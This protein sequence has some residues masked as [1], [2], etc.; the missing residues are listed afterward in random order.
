M[1]PPPGKPHFPRWAR[2]NQHI[3]PPPNRKTFPENQSPANFRAG[4]GA[5]PRRSHIRGFAQAARPRAIQHG[6]PCAFAYIRNAIQGRL[7]LAN[8]KRHTFPR[9]RI[10]KLGRRKFVPANFRA[11][12]GASAVMKNLSGGTGAFRF[13]VHIKSR[14]LLPAGAVRHKARVLVCLRPLWQILQGG[15]EIMGAR[16]VA[17]DFEDGA[18]CRI[19]AGAGTPLRR[20]SASCQVGAIG[21]ASRFYVAVAF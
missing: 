18:T 21:G 6:G 7:R 9:R 11:G 10:V 16:I 5:I 13:A 4:R 3:P 12:R 15:A 2:R 20:L 1:S 8:R 14:R 19:R 17:L